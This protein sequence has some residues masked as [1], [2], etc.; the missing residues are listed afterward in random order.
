MTIS[1]YS[2]DFYRQRTVTAAALSTNTSA[3]EIVGSAISIEG[4]QGVKF[5]TQVTGGT[6][7]VTDKYLKFKKIEFGN[8]DFSANVTSF[9][10]NSDYILIDGNKDDI[11]SLL[12]LTAI[13]QFEVGIATQM[14]VSGQTHVR[15]V[16]ETVG[17]SINI[18]SQSLAVKTLSNIS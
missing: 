8:S 5:L 18:I 11:A 13:G 9:D 14:A 10:I 15:L 2:Q 3:G 6:G 1:K 4:C 12:K 17:D 16:N 7:L